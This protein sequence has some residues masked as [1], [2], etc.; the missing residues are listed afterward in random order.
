MLGQQPRSAPD[1]R[2]KSK[3]RVVQEGEAWR[4]VKVGSVPS[5][6]SDEGYTFIRVVP[7]SY[8]IQA[9]LAVVLWQHLPVIPSKV[10]TQQRERRFNTMYV[11]FHDMFRYYYSDEMAIA[12]LTLPPP[13]LHPNNLTMENGEWKNGLFGGV[14]GGDCGTCVRIVC[15]HL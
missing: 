9:A 15:I 5:R 3:R 10:S 8:C 11:L 14:C 4:I 1:P 2:G 7:L 12:P 13:A 6:G